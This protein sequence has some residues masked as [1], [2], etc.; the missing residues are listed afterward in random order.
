MGVQKVYPNGFKALYDLSFGVEKGQILCILGPNGAG[1]STTFD[2][3][4]Q[5]IPITSGYIER[6]HPSL[7]IGLCNQTNT[8]WEGL[9]VIENLNIYAC[10]KGL[11]NNEANESIEYLL[12]AL[13]LD[14]YRK[15]KVMELSEGTKRKLN[16]ALCVLGAPDLILLDE[17]TT[18]VDPIG[19]SQIW[20]LL[21][22]LVKKKECAVIMSTHY[23]EDAELIADKLGNNYIKQIIK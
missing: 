15:K 21:K 3:L 19:R 18:G 5:K 4:T 9:S 17:P 22:A 8:L 20:S 23:M 12:D 1:K 16:V 6:L 10:I 11:T 2:V 14:Q 13:S 7:K